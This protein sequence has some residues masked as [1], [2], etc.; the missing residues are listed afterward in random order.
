MMILPYLSPELYIIVNGRP[1]KSK[2]V[3]CSLIDVN[4]VKA[5]I[6]KL[7]CISW[8]Y[9]DMGQGSVDTAT[10]QIIEVS[11]DY[12]LCAGEGYQG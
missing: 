4:K 9:K 11:N 8:L 6:A 3:C 10:Q 12:Y 5:A 2:V 7:R 1:T